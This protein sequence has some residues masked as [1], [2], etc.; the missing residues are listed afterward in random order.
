MASGLE[1]YRVC[2]GCCDQVAEDSSWE[3]QGC[4]G[5]VDRVMAFELRRLHLC[6]II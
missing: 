6:Q 1:L 3:Y 4:L 5:V 2:R